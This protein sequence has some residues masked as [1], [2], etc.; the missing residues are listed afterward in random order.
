MPKAMVFNSFDIDNKKSLVSW[1]K[2]FPGRKKESS[3]QR[4]LVEI[5]DSFFVYTESF[6]HEVI[7]MRTY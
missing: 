1:G 5:E 4:S 6:T 3:C 7:E 2:V